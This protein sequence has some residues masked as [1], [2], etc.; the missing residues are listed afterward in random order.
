HVGYKSEF[1]CRLHQNICRL[2]IT[3]NESKSMRRMKGV[4]DLPDQFH[5]LRQAQ[6]AHHF[7]QRLPG[8]VLH[9]DE[10]DAAYFTRLI[11]AADMRIHNPPLSLSLFEKPCLKLRIVDTQ[12]LDGDLS[13]QHRI[14]RAVNPCHSAFTD[15][16][17]VAIP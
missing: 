17:K 13:L 5:L 4:C 7:F 9:G 15:E 6:L 10:R 8:D 1:L 11:N 3:M 14:E 16:L 12:L 2:N